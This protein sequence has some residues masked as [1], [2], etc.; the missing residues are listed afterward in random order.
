MKRRT[1]AASVAAAAAATAALLLSG[2]SSDNHPGAAAV[3]G[4]ERISLASVQAQVEAVRAAQRAQ[5]NGDQLLSGSGDLTR[6]TVNFLVY[7]EVLERAAADHGVRV[8]RRAVQEARDATEQSLGGA[9]ALRQVALAPQSGLPVAGD[10]QIDRMLR[11]QLLYSGLAQRLGP[12]GDPQ[13]AQQRLIEA[14]TDTANEIGVDVNPRYGAWDAEN[15]TLAEAD[16][17]WLRAE[18]QAQ[19]GGPVTLDG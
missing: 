3:V 10:E 4:G 7:E 11:S 18:E 8:S 12:A 13:T 19:A 17:P 15:I 6:Q 5:P 14:L 2:C 16:E 9:E 1:S